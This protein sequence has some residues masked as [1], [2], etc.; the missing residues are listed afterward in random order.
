MSLTSFNSIINESMKS[1]V[2]A[3]IV[4]NYKRVV[5]VFNV[6]EHS[7]GRRHVV[8]LLGFPIEVLGVVLVSRVLVASHLSSPG[9]P[10]SNAACSFAELLLLLLLL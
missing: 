6:R 3:P 7:D 5:I 9:H 1:T 10:K 8:E 4:T 2:Q